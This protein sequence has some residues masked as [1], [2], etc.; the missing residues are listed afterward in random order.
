MPSG[1]RERCR[2]SSGKKRKEP[3]LEY[4]CEKDRQGAGARRR[5]RKRKYARMRMRDQ[6]I[7]R[8]DERERGIRREE[9]KRKRERK[10]R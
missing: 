1:W 2:K 8:A 10:K 7:E 3:S 6:I 4:K 5:Y 9:T